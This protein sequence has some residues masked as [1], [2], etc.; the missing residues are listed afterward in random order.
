MNFGLINSFELIFLCSSAILFYGFF[1]KWIVCLCSLPFSAAEVQ[2]HDNW[3]W[4]CPWTRCYSCRLQ[5]PHPTQ[6]CNGYLRLVIAAKFSGRSS[7][8]TNN[9][10]LE[11]T[12][13]A[14]NFMKV[15]PLVT[16]SSTSM[17][18]FPDFFLIKPNFIALGQSRHLSFQCGKKEK[19]REKRHNRHV[20]GLT[21]SFVGSLQQAAQPRAQRPSKDSP[22][23]LT[24][25]GSR[26]RR[27]VFILWTA[28]AEQKHLPWR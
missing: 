6:V 14:P 24:V 13:P 16:L 10:H 9:T 19:R 8:L 2:H 12:H 5:K 4:E 22:A 11:I 25:T 26:Q 7:H 1:S 15:F 18:G 20:L 23:W 17:E 28:L 27:I 3:P 21:C